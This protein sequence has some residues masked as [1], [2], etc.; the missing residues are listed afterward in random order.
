MWGKPTA[1]KVT[2]DVYLHANAKAGGKRIRQQVPVNDG[3]AMVTFELEDG[4]RK[5]PLE[6]QQLMTAASE[7]LALRRD[8]INQQLNAIADESSLRSLAADRQVQ[9]QVAANGGA[10]FVRMP[11][12]GFQPVIIVLPSG[13]NLRATGVISADRR[14]VRFTGLPLFSGVSEVNTFNLFTGASG[15][16]NGANSGGFGGSGLG[17]LGS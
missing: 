5:D 12:A 13:A 4:R 15:T 14:Y 17:G 8:L 16:S 3:D 9:Q 6:E 11:A 1:G 2:V 10:P 7:Q